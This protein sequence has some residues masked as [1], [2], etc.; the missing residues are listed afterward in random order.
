MHQDD[1][2]F[3]AEVTAAAAAAF[4]VAGTALAPRSVSP[5][6]ILQV[7]SCLTPLEVI[8]D[9]CL[10]VQDGRIGAVGGESAFADLA[11]IPRIVRPGCRAIPGM[12]DTHLH[13]CGGYDLMHIGSH[14]DIAVMSTTLARH[15]VTSFVPTV[16]AAPQPQLLEILAALA[17]LCHR[18]RQGA[19]PVGIHLE[20]PF[21]NPL[22]RGTQN[23]DF[24]R[25]IDLG[26]ARELIAA[27][28]GQLRLMTF[29]PELERATGLIELLLANRAVPSMGHSLADEEATLRA[30]DA[31]TARCTHFYNGMPLLSQREVGLTAVALNDDRVTIELIADGV[32]VN[33][34][35]ID[36]ACRA[37]PC[38]RVVGISDGSPGS[39]LPRGLYEFGT[40]TVQIEGGASRRLSDGRLA[41]SGLTLD[42]VMANF[43]AFCETLDEMAA[44]ACFTLNAA[45]GIGL[46]DRGILQP[47]KRAD[48]TVLDAELRVAMTIVEGHIVYDREADGNSAGG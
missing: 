46:D 30:I 14:P 16:L 43:Q 25:Q 4:P 6:F 26:E 22:K 23:A 15:G 28:A 36:L 17:Q 29:A 20:G 24:I 10:L 35:M 5:T 38:D 9:A 11:D 45:R 39:G 21:I 40:D 7:D 19:V 32:H 34:R 18:S 37:K 2:D 42:V 27:A 31:G 1:V 41:G 13:G 8:R 48:I 33:P 44:F 47:G 12:I 3:Q